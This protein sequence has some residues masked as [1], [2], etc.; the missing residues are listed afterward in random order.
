[1]G[2]ATSRRDLFL[3]VGGNVDPLTTAMKA[4]KSALADFG[5]TSATLAEQI[6]QNIQKMGA[7]A[8]ATARQIEQ[9][10]TR[11]FETIRSNA[12]AVVEATSE[13]SASQI[14]NVNGA[15]AAADAA[16][17]QAV[18]LRTVADAAERVAL[19]EGKAGSA[20]A[21]YATAA[22][23]VAI[24]AE[25]QAVALRAQANALDLVQREMGVTV[26]QS[27]GV[28]ASH[29]RMGASG[30]ILQHVIRSTNDSFA[31]GL[32]I[33]M[34]VTE[35]MGRLTEAVAL[36]GGAMGK[37][38]EIMGG[39]FGIAATIALTALAPLIAKM[40]EE[41]DALT[42]ASDK[43]AKEAAQTAIATQAHNLFAQSLQGQL[44]I[45]QK[46]NDEVERGLRSQHQTDLGNAAQADTQ[47]DTFQR[48]FAS[49]KKALAQARA[50]LAKAKTKLSGAGD[51]ASDNA[52]AASEVAIA[53]STVD[54]LQAKLN[55]LAQAVAKAKQTARAAQ[56]PLM[57]HDVA[58]DIDKVTAATN[59]Y[60][61]AVARLNTQFQLGLIS[62]DKYT[63]ELHALGVTRDAE[64]KAARAEKHDGNQVG[65][66]ISLADAEAIVRA[67]GGNVTSDWRTRAQQQHLWDEK[68][69]GRHNGPVAPPGTSD[70]ERGQA[71]DIAYAP[72][73]TL[74]KIKEA[75]RAAGVT[76][77]QALDEPGQRVY[78]IAWG[79][80]GPSAET[81]QHRQ[82]AA[83][84][85]AAN[86]DRAYQGQLDQAQRGY[87][88]ALLALN[89]NAQDRLK[90][91]L[92][93][94]EAE[95]TQ[96]DLEIDDLVTAKKITPAQAEKLKHLNATTTELREESAVTEEQ[97][98]LLHEQLERDRAE[99]D[100]QIAV[101]QLQS[102]LATTRKDR[103]RI[104]HEILDRERQEL[105]ARQQL[106]ID[107]PKSTQAERDAARAEQARTNQ[108]YDLRG[109]VTDK[110]NQDPLHDYLDRLKK[111]TGDMN[112]ALKGVEADGLQSLEDG[113][114]GII[115][116]TESVGSAFK[117]M[118][119][120]IIADLARIAI[121]KAIVSI[122]G[123]FAGGGQPGAGSGDAPGFAL[124][125]IPGYAT[126][127]GE[128]H[129]AGTG[130]SDSILAVYGG[131]K[132]IRVS[133]GEFIMNAAATRRYRPM[134]QAMNDNKLSGFALGG[135]PGFA[136]GGMPDSSIYYPQL[137]S[138]GSI[139]PNNVLQLSM[140]V[141]IHAPGAD[142][143]Q[144]ARVAESIDQLRNEMP[145]TAIRAVAEAQSRNIL[146]FG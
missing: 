95:K 37:V 59:R 29:T 146:R 109:Q 120:Q 49:T 13:V 108:Q 57:Q 62:K 88:Q 30:M 124:G 43:L 45:Q 6:E 55:Q 81:L 113:L 134:I 132:L 138:P 39:P 67:I 58:G 18:A 9:S 56:I 20:S 136:E 86:D 84:A 144:L 17:A 19:A 22:H 85:R 87:A 101:L 40:F 25:D 71:I 96:R 7:S 2:A 26:D 106:V 130:T 116:G 8:P 82:D 145:A 89:D 143:A 102:E 98:R 110:Q 135:L 52:A 28:V 3:Q 70:H 105:L 100:G 117:K 27:A 115:N 78:H 142:A 4:G 133:N 48:E 23:T 79:K 68:Q 137:P 112:D 121:E 92:Q 91:D 104:A 61:D 103:L 10:F 21:I 66:E 140:P 5:A 73:L 93:S 44:E 90:I 76:L 129:G 111:S 51:D 139:A 126:G 64:V 131:R 32:P 46:L 123:S 141:S 118:A 94:L 99:L 63:S 127:G 119:D 47:L 60:A 128:I 15:R 24:G 33:T 80:K 34:I 77:R 31:A 75:F 69:A 72:G 83:T 122:L 36:S 14:L 54:A 11:T 125:G 12:R 38:G 50:D 97:S 41:S 35:Q 107:D 114:L 1:M 42:L 53:Q 16:E 74:A 65:R